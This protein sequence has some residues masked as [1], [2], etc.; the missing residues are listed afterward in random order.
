M[1]LLSD[2]SITSSVNLYGIGGMKSAPLGYTMCLV[3]VQG[4]T[5][6]HEDNIFLVVEDNSAFGKRVPVVIGTP[7]LTRALRTAKESEHPPDC[8]F[9][10]CT[11]LAPEWEQLQYDLALTQEIITWR[12]A[13]GGNEELS[14]LDEIVKTTAD[15]QVPPFSTVVISTIAKTRAIGTCLTITM[16]PLTPAQTGRKVPHGLYVQPTLT[17]MDTSSNRVSVVVRN[18]CGA[19][20]TLPKHIAIARV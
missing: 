14:N 3:E 4:I 15:I 9:R 20:K 8:E 19:E 13:M 2:L 6:Y 18:M 16:E 7:I 1:R 12:A 5:H 10:Q 17:T 11:K